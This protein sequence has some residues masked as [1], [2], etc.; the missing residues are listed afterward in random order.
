M[1]RDFEDVHDLD[2]LSD[3]ELRE[4]VRQHLAD[5]NAIDL[6]DIT[7]SAE[8]GRVRLD[9]RVGTDQE[10]RTADHILTDVLGLKDV[11]NRIFVDA[12]RRALHSDDIEETLAEEESEEGLLLG[13]RPDSNS[14]TDAIASE[15]DLDSRLWGTTDVQKSIG[16]GTPWIPPESPTPEGPTGRGEYGED[17]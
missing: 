4:L 17:H 13:D 14:D 6:D 9:G 1:A 3:R 2:N 16:E 11:D 10:R 8:G 7:V 12:S 5:S 15:N